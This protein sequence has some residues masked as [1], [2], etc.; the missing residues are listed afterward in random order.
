MNENKKLYIVLVVIVLVIAL[1]GG[2][3]Y[4]SYKVQQKIYADF[5]DK[6]NSDD[7]TL[8]YIGR[9]TCGYCNLLSPSLDDMTE[10]YDFGYYYINTDEISSGTMKKIL[11]HF[12]LTSVGTP[13]LAVVSNGKIVDTQNGYA[14][15]DVV[16][17]F[18]KKNDIIAEDAK[19]LLNY[20]GL[21]EYKN[22][23]A[24]DDLNVI[25]VGQSTCQFCVRAKVVLNEIVEQKNI[26]INYVNISYLDSDE[27]TEFDKTLDYLQ[28]KY[29]TPVMLITKGGNLVD[30]YEGYATIDKYIEFLEKNGVL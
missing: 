22:E 13:Y 15:Y 20:I 4:K 14:D 1:I 12:N 27:R 28:T 19:L 17:E 9:P 21:D 30:K 6:F 16:F 26:E 18:L 11:S 8:F 25:V 24:S 7:S 10:R 23:L 29:G 2:L 3:I 5:V